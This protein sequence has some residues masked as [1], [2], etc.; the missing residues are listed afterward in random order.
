MN[1]QHKLIANASPFSLEESTTVY[2][3]SA[4]PTYVLDR[5]GWDCGDAFVLDCDR[6]LHVASDE[7]PPNAPEV[8]RMR[9]KL[10]WG[11]LERIE[12]YKRAETEPAFADFI[13]LLD[14][15]LAITVEMGNQ[16]VAYGIGFIVNSLAAIPNDQKAHR[17]G[18]ILSNTDPS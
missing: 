9:F 17:Y 4:K 8:S 15:P 6:L 11:A 12:I 18:Q 13:R 1:Q 16:S 14:D 5:F 7:V 2:I 3:G 10:L